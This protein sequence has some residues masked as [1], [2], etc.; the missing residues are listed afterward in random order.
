VTVP[1]ERVVVIAQISD[2]HI[3]GPAVGSGER[4]SEAIAAVNAMTRPPDLVLVTGDLTHSGEPAE[5]DELRSRI[6]DLRAPWDAI[7]GNHDRRIDAL[8]GH[9]SLELGAM[10]V[11]LLDTSSDEFVDAD[12][13]WLDAELAGHP[14]RPVVIAV[15]H[16]PFETGIWWMDCVGLRGAERLEAVV[17]R[18]P[19][20][21]HVMSGHVHRPITTSWTGCLVTA[22]PSTAVAVAGDLDPAHDPA[23]TAEPPMIALHAYLADAVV[24]HV[25]AVGD[26]AARTSIAA[27]APEFVAWA[28][29]QQATRP[30]RFG[31]HASP[32]RG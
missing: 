26:A 22:C 3:G 2:V 31:V 27:T 30:S 6:A 5:W 10:R 14:D 25:V 20:V 17:R 23:E 7:R 4:F 28:R 8:V 9:R 19:H 16:P 15:H 13:E 21:L 18:H 24:S 32:S 12:A 11:V 29:E 1:A